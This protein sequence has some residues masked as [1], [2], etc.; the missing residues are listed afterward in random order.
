[1]F[2]E[3]WKHTDLNSIHPFISP[4]LSC[5]STHDGVMTVKLMSLLHLS[6][7][8]AGQQRVCWAPRDPSL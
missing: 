1:M 8:S 3:K 7:A 4:E 5:G 2:R 6:V